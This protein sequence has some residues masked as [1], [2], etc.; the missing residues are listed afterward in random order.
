MSVLKVVGIDGF[1]N[2]V[3]LQDGLVAFFVHADWSEAS[4]EMIPFIKEASEKF[5]G[6][7]K[8]AEMDADTEGTVDLFRDLGIGQ[9]P[10]LVVIKDGVPIATRNSYLNSEQLHSY[11]ATFISE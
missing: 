8:F 5:R 7:I 4:K 3:M 1:T 9:V 11:L 2:I 10:A 6:S